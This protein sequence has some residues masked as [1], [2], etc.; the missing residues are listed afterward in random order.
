MNLSNLDPNLVLSL[1][2]LVGTGIAWIVH[3]VR[4]DKVASARDILD[5]LVTQALNAPGVNLDN[6]KSRVEKAARDAL[7]KRGI[8]GAIAETLVH[9]FVEY[10][11]AQLHERFDLITRNVEQ[12]ADAAAKVKAAMVPKGD[13]PKLD[14]EIETVP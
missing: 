13:F 12:M 5:S 1:A 4:G 6:I 7:A 9:E 2:T 11:S 10:A 14:I 8:K 3:K